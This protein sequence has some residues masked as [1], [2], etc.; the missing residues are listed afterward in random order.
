[1]NKERKSDDVTRECLAAISDTSIFGR[2]V[3][4]ELTG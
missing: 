2:C 1:M 4:R 3:A